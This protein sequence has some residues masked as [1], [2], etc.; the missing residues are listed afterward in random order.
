[1]NVQRLRAWLYKNKDTVSEWAIITLLAVLPFL[2]FWR[3]VTL[4]PPDQQAIVSG[5]FTEQYFPLRA[6]SASEWVQGRIP[7]WNPA[8]Y[9][10]QPALADPQSGALYP[11]H[12]LQALVLGWGGWGFPIWALEHQV[13]IHFSIAAIGAYLLGCFWA[14]SVTQT[15]RVIRLMG[16]VLSI[17]FTYSGYLTSFP[18]QQMT[19][20]QVS[21]WLPWIMWMLSRCLSAGRP[22]R[23]LGFNVGWTSLFFALAI[24]A[25]HPQT[26]LYIFYLTLAYAIFHSIFQVSTSGIFSRIKPVL[27]WGISVS[28][29]CFL[30]AAQLWPTLEFIGHSLRAD[31]S[32]EAVSLGLPLSELVSILYPGYF[33]GSPQYVGIL[34]LLLVAVGL[35]IPHKNFIQPILFWLGITLLSLLLAFGTNTFLYPLIYLL[36]PGFDAVRQQERVYL[37]YSFGIA[38]MAS[39][40]ALRLAL[41]MSSDEKTTW[42]IFQ[43]HLHKVSIFALTLT[44]L[45]I[46]GSTLANE[47]GD[48]VNLFAGVLR[49]HMFGLVLL[50]GGLILLALRPRHIWRRWWGICLIVGWIGFNL[51]T[52]NW[53]YNLEPRP[54]PA[55]FAPL[56]T[57]LFLQ[58][59]TAPLALPVRV[60]SGG[61]L[62]G[63][64]S[65]ASVLG[66]EDVTGNTPLQLANVATFAE[67]MPAWR[68]W[69]L[70][71]VLYVV[72]KRDI[73]GPGLARRYEASGIKVY[74]MGDPLPRARIIHNIIQS[75]DWMIL[76]QDEVDLKT[77]ALLPENITFPPL[78]TP[79]SVAVSVDEHSPGRLSISV[80]TDAQALLVISNIHYPGWQA[81]IDEV[82]VDIYPTNG[83]FQGI[84]VPPGSHLVNLQFSPASFWWGLWFSILGLVFTLS[85]IVV[86]YSPKQTKKP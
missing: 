2:F 1:M 5:D 49:H 82:P 63:G 58:E 65:A 25:G 21:A 71:N 62:N 17:T 54:N 70:M 72:D 37:V 27:L 36:V 10:G 22:L 29:G 51:F 50:A 41:P 47:R 42:H 39:Y 33:G 61:F 60:N 7:L 19:I 18:V 8:L 83:I 53:R 74:E 79:T 67:Q 30:A 16:L 78:G 57:N 69:Q 81:R 84:L 55:P 4:N 12:I 24:L 75:D 15:P 73:D 46:Y 13:I 48:A 26:V 31:L 9:G 38:V 76:G 28:L 68:Y 23:M 20:L 86:G 85:L 6:F 44:G 80:N 45:F 56:E 40:G 35:I 3:V 14:K 59:H 32:Y 66:L 43:K 52:I 34:P 77:T 11:P 64:N